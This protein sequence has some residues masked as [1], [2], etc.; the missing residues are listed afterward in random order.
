MSRESIFTKNIS[1]YYQG[2]VILGLILIGQ[3]GIRIT[4]NP[5]D[6]FG[7]LDYWILASA[8]L[9]LFAVV[10]SVFSFSAKNPMKYY[11]K[12]VTTFLAVA[13]LGGLAA[14]LFSGIALKEAGSFSWIYMVLTIIFVVFLTI[15]NLI[16][17]IVEI[18]KKQERKLRNEN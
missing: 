9:L 15:V 11:G 8:F 13:F 6:Q 4:I 3:I 14:Y 16:R 2:A 5:E 17:K 7:R 12:S 18:A 10:A 1:P